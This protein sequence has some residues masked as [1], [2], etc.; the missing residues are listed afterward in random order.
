MLPV[1]KES[2]EKTELGYFTSHLLPL[3]ADLMLKSE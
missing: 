1:M 2:I 3:A